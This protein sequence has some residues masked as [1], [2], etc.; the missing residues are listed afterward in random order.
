[1]G[2]KA[3]VPAQYILEPSGDGENGFTLSLIIRLNPTDFN[4]RIAGE[5]KEAPL[6]LKITNGIVNEI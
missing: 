6:L 5:A 2:I 1:N 3:R 4:I